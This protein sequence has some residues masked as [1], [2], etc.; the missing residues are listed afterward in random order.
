MFASLGTLQGHRARLFRDIARAARI[1]RR[2]CSLPMAAGWHRDLAATLPGRPTVRAFVP[3]AE[4]LAG[5]AA[6]VGHGGMKR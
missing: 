5:A 4:V 6:L 1:A 2:I 3:Q